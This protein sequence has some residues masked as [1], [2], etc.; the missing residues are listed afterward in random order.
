[1]RSLHKEIDRRFAN[2]LDPSND[3]F[4]P[5]LL[6]CSMLNPD[7][8]AELSADLFEHGKNELEH[9]LLLVANDES[10]TAGTAATSGSDIASASQ[11]QLSSSHD[12][13]ALPPLEPSSTSI[14]SSSTD[15]T[16]QLQRDSESTPS[17]S[18]HSQLAKRRRL[19]NSESAS[20]SMTQ[21]KVADQVATLLRTL[22]EGDFKPNI[23]CFE[24]WI[25]SS[26]KYSTF[27]DIAM[28]VLSIP[29][30]SASAERLFSLAGLSSSGRSN[31]IGRNCWRANLWL[32]LINRCCAKLALV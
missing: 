1:V 22:D 23:N 29:A 9:F 11:S 24:F 25:E 28:Q 5:T 20:Q 10:A 8:S 32:S 31:V 19:V 15:Q 7:K 27:A 14:A 2:I 3:S 16:G 12:T 6:I 26:V 17:Q 21:N 30:T 4:N 13:A 18:S